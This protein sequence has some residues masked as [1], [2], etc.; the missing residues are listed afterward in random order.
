[1]SG[2]MSPGSGSSLEQA[3]PSAYPFDDFVF[4]RGPDLIYAGV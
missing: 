2:E 4:V 1:M 3:Q